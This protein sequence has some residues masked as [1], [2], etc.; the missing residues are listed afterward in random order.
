MKR[1]II[2]SSIVGLLCYSSIAMADEDK[3]SVPFKVGMT[4]DVSL[5]SGFALGLETRLPHV[6]WF[7]VGVA[8]TYS[9][10]LGIRGN[11]LF[12][13]IK[14]PIA[15]IANIDLGHQFQFTIPNTK[16][17]PAIDFN[18]CDLNAGIGLGNRDGFRFM[19]LTGASYLWGTAH[20]FQGVLPTSNTLTI[21]D[22]N[23]RGWVPN[24]KVGFNFLF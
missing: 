22:P 2:I 14:F 9:L 18:Y 20:N 3:K 8:G 11:L 17:S 16:N 19:L 5:P 10:S 7:K 12:D 15:P 4:G 21:S 23:F 1:S 24:V 6:P 13:P